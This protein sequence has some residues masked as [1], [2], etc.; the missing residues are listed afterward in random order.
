MKADGHLRIKNELNKP[1]ES[2]QRL[3]PEDEEIL[4]NYIRDRFNHVTFDTELTDKI[5][6]VKPV[7][8]FPSIKD[9]KLWS[10]ICHRNHE[11][12]SVLMI[13]NKAVYFN[14]EHSQFKIFSA[15]FRN[16][17]KGYLYVEAYDLIHVI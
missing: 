16:A 1:L 8:T 15:G 9:P 7:L 11:R 3:N 5:T 13:M 10:I 4:Q 2:S 14:N 6:N 12:E 17:V